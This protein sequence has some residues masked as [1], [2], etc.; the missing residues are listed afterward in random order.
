M[1]AMRINKF[2][3][4]EVFEEVEVEKPSPKPNELLVKVYATSINPVDF[5]LRQSG[6]WAGLEPPVILG[7]DAAGVVEE[8]GAG[9]EDFQVGDEVY[10]TPEIFGNQ[11][12]TFA[13]Y[14][15]VE[16]NIVT[17]KPKNLS[18]NEAASIPL[19]G[20]TAWEAIVRQGLVEA[21]ETVLIHGVGGVGSFAVQMAIASGARVIAVC[22][23]YMV[24]QVRAYGAIP[25]N[26][27]S[28]DF[29]ERVN[30]LTDG[31]GV[32]LVVDTVG[33]DT[34]TKCIPLTKRYGRMVS[35]VGTSTGFQGAGPR[36]ITVHF[37]FLARERFIL[38]RLKTLSEREQ[39]VPLIDSVMDLSE[40]G[41][42]QR[43]LEQGGVKGKIVLKVASE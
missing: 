38:E 1:R 28:E 21:G 10:Y 3:G 14:N 16:A 42:A 39:I 17:H 8:V 13:E 12:G 11:H 43:R 18:F 27:K 35:I 7:Y 22:S 4:P 15:T 25:I 33:K 6:S 9:V 30:E 2:G 20:G 41:D 36:N 37:L 5:K 19:A 26:Y 34:L 23:D 29:V 32:D 40:V 31:D 24:D